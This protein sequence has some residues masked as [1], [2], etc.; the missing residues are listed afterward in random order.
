MDQQIVRTQMHLLRRRGRRLGGLLG[1]LQE[2]LLL[3]VE[4]LFFEEESLPF[5]EEEGP[6]LQEEL[7]LAEE[8]VGILR[9]G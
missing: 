4:V 7:P 8:E 3:A 1:P 9:G 6:L 5:F 2:L